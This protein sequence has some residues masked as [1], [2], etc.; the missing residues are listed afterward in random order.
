MF[1]IQNLKVGTKLSFGFGFILILMSLVTINAF[2]GFTS[3]ENDVDT[4]DDVTGW[5][6]S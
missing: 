2:H 6:N 5:L 1:N 3:L 4:A